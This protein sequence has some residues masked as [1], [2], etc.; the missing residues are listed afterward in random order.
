MYNKSHVIPKKNNWLQTP[1]AFSNWLTTKLRKKHRHGG[2]RPLS[3]AIWWPLWA[4]PPQWK[5]TDP[6]NN[7]LVFHLPQKKKKQGP[8][9]SLQKKTQSSFRT[10]VEFAFHWSEYIEWLGNASKITGIWKSTYNYSYTR[11][12]K[13]RCQPPLT[14][15][16][17][18]ELQTYVPTV[19]F[20][21][22]TFHTPKGTGWHH[23]DTISPNGA[24]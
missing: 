9:F 18:K 3:W 11:T 23:Q 17:L 22:R 4:Y 10:C 19:S 8:F 15:R 16:K 7:W 2:K 13:E 1:P 6:Q 5:V 21:F 12:R 14:K 20:L 24:S